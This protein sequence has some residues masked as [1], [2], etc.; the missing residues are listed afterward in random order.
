M[1]CIFVDIVELNT[2]WGQR[3]VRTPQS[4]ERRLRFVS[5]D[6]VVAKRLDL[7]ERQLNKYDTQ[8]HF[9]V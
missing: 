8:L 2:G 9:F 7:A 6:S 3:S 4:I 5:Q 1:K